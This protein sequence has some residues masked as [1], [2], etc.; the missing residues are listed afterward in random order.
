MIT[1]DG[2][3]QNLY[4]ARYGSG[5]AMAHHYRDHFIAEGWIDAQY[6]ITAAGLIELAKREGEAA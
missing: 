3:L 1:P 4:R 6:R 5:E 2:I